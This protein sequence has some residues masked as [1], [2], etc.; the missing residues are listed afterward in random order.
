MDFVYTLMQRMVP[1]TVGMDLTE[2]N[3]TLTEGDVRKRDEETFR[4]LFTFICEQ[5]NNPT[6]DQSQQLLS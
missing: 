4:N 2:V 6:L 3:F 5:V 1:Q